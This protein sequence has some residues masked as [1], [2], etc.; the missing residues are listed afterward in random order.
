MGAAPSV[1]R[2]RVVGVKLI[3]LII[4]VVITTLGCVLGSIA[5]LESRR[6]ACPPPSG[7]VLVYSGKYNLY[8]WV[9]NSVSM[10]LLAS[11]RVP[12]SLALR[13]SI[14]VYFICTLGVSAWA[15]LL[16][17]VVFRVYTVNIVGIV[18]YFSV[19]GLWCVLYCV[20]RVSFRLY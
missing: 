1:L 3:E 19:F 16:Y 4:I 5:C 13:V 11:S 14:S 2:G 8:L 9:R 10:P 6:S 15:F 18:P 12:V 20:Y 7:V 17:M